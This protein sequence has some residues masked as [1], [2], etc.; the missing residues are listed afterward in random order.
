MNFDGGRSTMKTSESGGVHTP[1]HMLPDM[2]EVGPVSVTSAAVLFSQDVSNYQSVAIQVTSPGTS[3][4]ITYEAS[5]DSVTWYAVAGYTPLNLGT[6][7]PVTTSTAAILLVFPCM[8]RFFRPRVS[9]YGS[10]TVTVLAEFRPEM[11]DHLGVY[12]F[13]QNAAANAV[14][15]AFNGTVAPASSATGAATKAR[16]KSAAGTNA[17]SVKASAGR[18][19]EIHVCNTSTTMKF[20][21]FY[22][23]ASAPTVGTD[24]PAATYP[25][26]PN[27]GRVDIASILGIS[28]ATGIAY[29]ITGGDADSDTTAGA[30]DD[31]TGEI[32]YA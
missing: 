9:V 22:N 20:L 28:L 7:A 31:V 10:G 27:G 24:T 12:A 8:A 3:C 14:P 2:L 17:T 1:C 16:V 25:N 5:N 30:V 13:V 4:T 21:K 11:A 19:Y 18:L 32:L 26:A 29:A 6:T 15:I 23:K